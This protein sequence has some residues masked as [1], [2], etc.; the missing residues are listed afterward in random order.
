MQEVALCQLQ[1]GV[2]AGVHLSR[3]NI[4]ATRARPH[5]GSGGAARGD[6]LRRRWGKRAAQ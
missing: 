3:M 4:V 5:G 6:A 1:H 2:S